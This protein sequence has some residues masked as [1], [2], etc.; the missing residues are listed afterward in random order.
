M[1][2]GK[3]MKGRPSASKKKPATTAKK[4]DNARRVTGVAKKKTTRRA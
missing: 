2:C 3:Y 1:P 4:M